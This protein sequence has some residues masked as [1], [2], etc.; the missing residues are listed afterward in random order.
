MLL[1][2]PALSYFQLYQLCNEQTEQVLAFGNGIQLDIEGCSNYLANGTDANE[3]YAYQI[4]VMTSGSAR[5]S[6]LTDPTPSDTSALSSA[7]KDGGFNVETLANIVSGTTG[8][9]Q[10]STSLTGLIEVLVEGDDSITPQI[11]G[12]LAGNPPG[13]ST[14]GK[15]DT[16]TIYFDSLT[17]KPP[18]STK[19]DLD[20]ILTFTPSLGKDYM[21]VWLSD[22]SSLQIT[23]VDPS[24]P[25]ADT[26]TPTST[27]CVLTFNPNYDSVQK[28]ISAYLG[29]SPSGCVGTHLCDAA[30]I[31]VGVCSQNKLS[32]R[33]NQSVSGFGG[34]FDSITN[35]VSGS[36][37]TSLP[38]Y[39]AVLLA[40]FCVVVIAIILVVV[41]Y[42]Y[43][44]YK[45]KNQRKEALRVV[46]RWKK[47]TYAPGKAVKKDDG[48]SKV[49]SKPPDTHAMRTV[50]D[51]FVEEPKTIRSGDSAGIRPATAAPDVEHLLPLPQQR[52][53]LPRSQPRIPTVLPDL[54]SIPDQMPRTRT[55]P[56]PPPAALVRKWVALLCAM[57]I[58]ISLFTHRVLLPF[59]ILKPSPK[60]LLS[61]TL[62]PVLNL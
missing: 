12:V 45:L 14:Y 24:R 50:I 20:K 11:I 9:R 34:S 57:T 61:Q 51:P 28:P 38:N 6:V 1:L 17:N 53:F 36:S 8:V 33:V 15:G 55:V 26:L 19:A 3:L 44:Q 2:Q 48:D 41:F 10:E 43:R 22:G 56:Q 39:G 37:V 16:V 52:L 13:D 49:W 25:S 54:H 35:P 27:N 18:V 29:S 5:I 23:V 31:S 21:G 47:D 46:Q 42:C 62:A 32:C 59:P 7:V 60:L 4:G 30:G 40:I 58:H